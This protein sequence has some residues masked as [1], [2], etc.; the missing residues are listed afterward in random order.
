VRNFLVFTLSILFIFVLHFSAVKTYADT[1]LPPCDTWTDLSGSTMNTKEAISKVDQKID[2]I[3]DLKC[4]SVMTAV[5]PIK[6]DATGFVQSIFK[7]VLGLAGGIALIL[8]IFSGYR[9]MASQGNPEAVKAATEQ[10]TSAII[11]L[12][13]II[14]SFVILQMVGVDILQIP[15]FGK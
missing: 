10:L 7:I 8:I 5:G 11:G 12:L 3:E 9:Y 14:F 13:F 4:T 2:K 1:I 15:G 6:T